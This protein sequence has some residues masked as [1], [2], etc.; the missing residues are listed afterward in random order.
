MQP[1]TGRG[2]SWL[3]G[4]CGVACMD[5]NWLSLTKSAWWFLKSWVLLTESALGWLF[6]GSQKPSGSG[7]STS[8]SLILVWLIAAG[9]SSPGGSILS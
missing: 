5:A 2:I 4:P 3:K 1:K 6:L 7:M 8:V 9:F